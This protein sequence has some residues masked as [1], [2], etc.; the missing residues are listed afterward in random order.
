M[1]FEFAPAVRTAEMA[2]IILDGLPG[3]PTLPVALRIARGLVGADGVIG[4]VDTQRGAAARYADD[5]TFVH[6]RVDSC[7]PKVMPDIVV[8]A[9]AARVDVLIIDT[10]SSF[11]SGRDG[12]LMLVDQ[13]R[14]SPSQSGWSEARPHELAMMDALLDYPGHVIATL[15]VK[16]DVVVAAAQD[17]RPSGWKVAL[18]PDH[19]DGL[20]YDFHLAATVD[21][22]GSLTVTSTCVEDVAALQIGAIERNPGQEYGQALAD[23]FGQGE[24]LPTL[25]DYLDRAAAQD[26]TSAELFALAEEVETRGMAGLTVRNRKGQTGPLVSLL[27]MK[28]KWLARQEQQTPP[29]PPA[30]SEPDTSGLTPPGK[31]APEFV[32]DDKQLVAEVTLRIAHV[33]E[34]DLIEGIQRDLDDLRATGA[35]SQSDLGYLWRLLEQRRVDLGFAHGQAPAAAQA[36]GAAT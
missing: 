24:A 23:W 32:P 31:G 27:T 18:K 12:M 34:F 3:A 36:E 13:H 22:D 15:R 35:A 16:S 1:T 2:R 5:H 9:V 33:K 19:R 11:W 21:L 14:K 20:E 7:S 29:P 8:A 25:R 17:G 6:L 26:A 4:V 30:P 10:F 28:A